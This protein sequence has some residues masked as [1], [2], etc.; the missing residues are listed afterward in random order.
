MRRLLFLL[1]IGPAAAPGQ[2]TAAVD[3]YPEARALLL[4]AELSAENL[5]QLADGSDPWTWAGSLYARAGYLAD[6][7]RVLG[8]SEE[9]HFIVWTA[10]VVYGDLAGAEAS[11]DKIS[12]PASK[13]ECYVALANLLWRMQKPELARAR[14]EKARM[15]AAGIPSGRERTRVLEGVRLGM[16]YVNDPRP[17]VVSPEPAPMPKQ[18][19]NPPWLPEFPITTGG[20]RVQTPS[21]RAAQMKADEAYLKSLYE[22]IAA[23]DRD[24][25][26]GIV[27]AAKTARQQTLGFATL[28]HL[29][30][31]GASPEAA[32]NVFRQMVEGDSDSRLAKA[33]ALTSA[34]AAWL[35]NGNS[36]AADRCF[37]DSVSLVNQVKELPMAK[38]TVILRVAQAQ[39]SGGMVASAAQTLRRA[40][41]LAEE[42]PERPKPVRGLRAVT[43][44]GVHYREEGYEKLMLAAILARDVGIATEIEEKWRGGGASVA[45]AW[46]EAGHRERAVAM[47]KRIVDRQNRVEAFLQMASHLLAVGGAPHF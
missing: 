15:I 45:L 37:R 27:K 14:F 30:I 31:Q 20:F 36:D 38:L 10:R 12:S 7:E 35:Q 43:P 3:L 42:L 44:P 5:R 24:G 25:A 6:A 26:F 9:P 33:E 18:R 16:T 39:G 19:P 4:A 1:L 2:G 41:E 47:A 40:R 32:E 11:I 34:G 28:G 23:K 46:L 8:P 17:I 21:A 13:A 29:L 22:R